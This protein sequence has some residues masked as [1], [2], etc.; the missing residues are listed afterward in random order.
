MKIGSKVV[1]LI[2]IVIFSC[3]SPQIFNPKINSKNG[4]SANENEISII[5]Y[6]IQSVFGKGNEKVIALADYLDS[7]KF[8]FVLMQEVFD[9]HVRNYFVENLDSSFYKAK[10]PRVDYSTFPSNICQD[11]GL[12][13]IS[14]F[15]LIDLS[16]IDF[17]ENTDVTNGAIHQ[18]LIKEFSISFDFMA[19]KSI[20]GTLHQIN[21]ST[22]LFMFTTH[23]QAISSRRHRTTQLKQIQAFIEN[24]VYTVLRNNLVESPQNLILLLTGDLNYNAYSE[25]DVEM[26]SKYLGNPRDLYKE[27]NKDLEEYTLIIK[28]FGLFRRVDY[29]FAFDNIGPMEFQKIDIKSINVTEVVD[30]NDESV[31][32]HL[33]LKATLVI[34]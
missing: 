9:E 4:G 30:E 24:A 27:F 8:D 29:I 6:N 17:G 16:H 22:K 1:I 33:A 13:S 32:D 28:L 26:L 21:D 19:N 25:D 18:M 7:E 31:S 2:S 34:D 23:L 3:A 5:T 14:K 11:A 10:V 12:F 15:P 20:L